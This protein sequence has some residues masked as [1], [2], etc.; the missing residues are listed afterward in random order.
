MINLILSRPEAVSK[1]EAENTKEGKILTAYVYIVRCADGRYYV[2]TTRGHL[3]KR[4]AEHNAGIFGGYTKSRRPVS[5]VY[6]QEFQRVDEAIAV[7]RQLKGWSRAKKEAL[8]R[9]DIEAL[10]RLAKPGS[11]HN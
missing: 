3:E 9:G 1:D 8:M 10:K 2:G 11:I 6:H 5:L 7:E 4:I